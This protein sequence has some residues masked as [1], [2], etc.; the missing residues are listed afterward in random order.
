MR[1]QWRPRLGMLIDELKKAPAVLRL[2]YV[3][4]LEGSSLVDDRLEAVKQEIIQAWGEFDG[5]SLTIE[6]EIFR[7][8][9]APVDRPSAHLPQASPSGLPAVSAGPPVE[10]AKPGEAVERHL[11]TAPPMTQWTQDSGLL[12]TEE[13][14]RLEERE[15]VAQD[16]ETVKLADVVPP[17]RFESGAAG[18]SPSYIARLREVLESMQH[19]RNV[20]LHLI[21][22]ADDQPL[23]GALERMYGDNAG[24]S[25]ERA[26]E[27]AEFLKTALGL[28]PD[29]VSFEW[30]GESQPVASNATP[31]GRAKNR[32]VEVEVW[33]DEVEERLALEEFV[34]SEDIKRV[35]ICR[36]E[37]VCKLRY[38]EGHAH[39]ARVKN[40]IAPLRV[41]DETVG[42][43]RDFVSQIRQALHNLRGKENVT[44]KF[45]GFTDDVP[46]TGR[47]ERIYGTHLSLSKA[48]ARRVALAV[49]ESLDLPSAAVDSDG[50][51]ASR[52][53]ASNDTTRGRA[54]NRRVEVEFWHDD[55][56]QELSDE[57]QLCPAAAS[58]ETVTRVYDP[59]WGRLPPIPI[60]DGQAQVPSGYA[61]QVRRAMA[62]VVNET[63]VRL[64]FIGYTRNERLD[65][66]T[67]LA[68]GDDIGLSAARARMTMRM[69]RSELS[70]SDELTEHEG[71]G[72]I[73]SN[74][75]V[76]AGFVQG[77]S[78][79]VVVQVVYDELAVLDDYE[80]V[81][82]T[83]ITRELSAR[84]P[85]ELNLMRISVDGKPIDD[86]SRSSADI[87]RCT[88]VA[89][90]RADIQF[91]FDNLESEA[92]LSVSVS[93][94]T[95][96]V[97][98]P[99]AAPPAVPE[100]P[101]NAE[102]T[103]AAETKE[104]IGTA[105]A[106]GAP[107][108]GALAPDAPIVRFRMYSNYAHFIERS[109][110]RIFDQERSLQ[111]PPLAVV[112]MD[113]E[114]LAE[115][116]PGPE[117]FA[118][119]TRL[120]KFV[121]RAYD[122]EGHF[123]QTAPQQLWMVHGDPEGDWAR[124]RPSTA[125]QPGK[126]P[127]L[128]GY[129]ETGPVARSI[130]LDN[131]GTVK[132]Q[133]S[134]IPANHQVWVAGSRVPV[135]EHGSFVADAVLPEGLHTV[136]V[137]VLDEVGN[138][139]LF[140]R[141]LELDQDDWFY[142]GIADVTL[143]ARSKSGSVNA[144]QGKKSRYDDDSWADG[145]LAFYLTGK[146]AEDW[147][148]TASADTREE[149]VT[150]LFSNFLD[151]SPDALFRRIDPDYHYPTF[152]DDSTVEEMAPTS[153]KL[154][155][156]LA[157]DQSHAMWGNF[158]VGYVQNELAQ[159]DR[160]L[161]GA[162]LHYQS[163]ATTELGEQRVMV[164]GF[165][166]NPGTVSSREDFRG[167]G[168]SLYFLRRQDVMT[169]S[170]RVRIETRDKDS[171]MVTGVVHLQP[172]LDYDVDYLQGRILLAEALES[173]VADGL[174]VRSQGL[175]GD[176][177]W[178]VVQYEYSPT[179]DELDSLTFGGQGHVWLN[180]YVKVG[181]TANR[182]DEG[183]NSTLYAGDVTVRKSTE[184]W[185]KFQVGR[186]EGLVGTT[187]RSDNGGFNF[188][189][190]GDLGLENA[191]AQAYR[192]DVSV[193]FGDFLDGGRGRFSFYGQRQEAGYSA[194][195]MIALTDTD[196][197]GGTLEMPVIEGLNLKAKADREVQDDGLTTTAADLNVDYELTDRWSMR[198]GVRHERRDDDSQVQ[199]ATQDEGDRT[200]G[201]V[202]VA[203]DSL[204]SWRG[205]GFGQATLASTGDRDDN[206]RV[207]V[208]GAYR[209]S[210]RFVVDGE[211]SHGDLGPAVKLGTSYQ[212]SEDTHRYFSYTLENERGV[213][214]VHARRGT[215][216]SGMRTRLADSGSVYM[217][218]RYQ[219]TDSGNGL[220]RSMGITLA[221]ADHWS[222]AANWELGSLF[223]RE[224]NAETK[225]RAG[226]GSIGYGSED[227]RA[228]VGI[229]YLYDKTEQP[230]KTKSNRTTWL[231]RN[232]AKY[233]A[234]PSMRILG[235]YNHSF[236][237]SSL[238][239]F[240]DGGYT[241]GV[242]GFAYR[243][244]THDKLNVLAKYTYF[245][246]VPTTDQVI[247]VDTPVEYIQKSHIAALDLSYDLT[248]RVTI[249][250]KYA[251]RRGEVSLDRKD[252]KFFSN[253]AHLYI[254]RG[255][256]RVTDNW[257]GSLEGRSLHL[258]DL[259]ER[260]SGALVTVY[261]YL[262]KH[263]KVG[264]GYN[265]TDFSDDLTDLSYD[266][267]GV[268]FN[269]I[270]TL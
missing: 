252:K 86:S 186:S 251:Y 126:D 207:G 153:G 66:R 17:V 32:R 202:E 160:G 255:D 83:P 110:V 25:R 159:V 68:Y 173:T 109:E 79:Y 38:K 33:Y 1:E 238:G 129:G 54:L 185:V 233:Q 47:A 195:G 264:I 13:G 211:V 136:E 151:K 260:R 250:G 223:D 65:R 46:L 30:A 269:L 15:V 163:L 210:D 93:P 152:G 219:H 10:E 69:M 76:N 11:P 268:F 21:G 134:G 199:A 224:T 183:S 64:R 101:G 230:D 226:G 121:L 14:D 3:A 95:V 12:E 120:L 118:A 142:V 200:D 235:K 164:D 141:D 177:V 62:D 216:I 138:G 88:D 267:H 122:A 49:K 82:V 237:D 107:A 130:P 253:D 154:Y 139:E 161:Y 57:P 254:L 34:V 58:A 213:D 131:A 203:Y 116:R 60:E 115:W 212:E 227:L 9:G 53:V 158:H 187:L 198:A 84:D 114:G 270:G 236:S 168:G 221:P 113:S 119:P 178:L 112:E 165:A 103:E 265:F 8:R 50:R 71:R 74:D 248:K 133:G 193:G 242:V 124:V 77:D 262:G 41:D 108:G 243:P 229:E 29:A 188:L 106:L 16:V 258:P 111:A 222:L 249:G 43:S 214:G 220:A 23:S 148:L 123:D 36:L 19:L 128:A 125:G 162:N 105:E 209:V 155:V 150:D 145:R 172:S 52:P 102:S 4:D 132:V 89:L 166:A 45:V 189:G 179:F 196:Q 7:H 184:S 234:T 244:V 205:Y 72:Y 75:V 240:Y 192:A 27:V 2:S 48:R 117:R 61:D 176:E 157:K 127:L 146:F 171:G 37:T 261:R 167:T 259:D 257:E 85:L 35:K 266:D 44:V 149:E 59:P 256:W 206:K 228:S 225:R 78:S 28:P 63:N 26:G 208:G 80:G 98:L 241:E 24:L 218:D 5:Y 190:T 175:S 245:Y 70:L 174:V 181:A 42:V 135:D 56:L 40:L 97:R 231:F 91:H 31:E 263:F 239:D 144:L 201:A 39:R 6:T 81:A 137:A 217:E 73:H 169:G 100:A 180:D 92:R 194:P 99:S 197:Y 170:E 55:P 22:H 104:P 51:G 147:R 18:I 232:S 67:A 90:E 156:K 140:L 191:D 215:V 87:Q 246:N 96:S 247:L 182:D 143:S 204:G 20:R 94:T